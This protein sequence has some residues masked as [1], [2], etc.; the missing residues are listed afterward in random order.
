MFVELMDE[1]IYIAHSV[2]SASVGGVGSLEELS[3]G[4]KLRGI[5]LKQ[6]GEGEVHTVKQII[7]RHVRA[8][9]H[10]HCVLVSHVGLA[11]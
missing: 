6:Q 7:W 2:A 5:E 8:D 9:P 10:H 1:F 3:N 4:R 11:L